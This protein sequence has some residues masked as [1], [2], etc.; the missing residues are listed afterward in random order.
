MN[1][2]RVDQQDSIVR[3]LL[4]TIVPVIRTTIPYGGGSNTAADTARYGR[5][6]S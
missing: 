3:T 1:G 5:D 6:R 2:E 4:S